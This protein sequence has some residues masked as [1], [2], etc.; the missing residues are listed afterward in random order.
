MTKELSRRLAL[1]PWVIFAELGGI[2]TALVYCLT[3]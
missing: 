1:A 3:H 2:A